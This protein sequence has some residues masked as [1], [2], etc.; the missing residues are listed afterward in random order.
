MNRSWEFYADIELTGWGACPENL[1]GFQGIAITPGD[2]MV[3]YGGLG[4]QDDGV[5]NMELDFTANPQ[6]TYTRCLA[7]SLNRKQCIQAVAIH[8]FGHSLGFAHEQMRPDT[9]ASCTA[10][11]PGDIP[12]DTLVGPWDG[13]SIMNYCSTAT[14]PS[15]GDVLGAGAMY[16]VSGRYVATIAAAI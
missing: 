11:Q 3:V 16:G 6:G 2:E 7:N 13:R 5:S 4:M 12:V 15:G 8:E 1:N 9:P 10:S 14:A